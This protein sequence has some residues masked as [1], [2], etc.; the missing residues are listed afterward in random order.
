MPPTLIVM[1]G[2]PVAG[3]SSVAERLSAALS[4]PVLS[5]DLIAAALW[6]AGIPK[7][8]TGR[9]PYQVA[10][11]LAAEQLTLGLSV[12]VDAVNAGERT[13]ALWRSLAIEHG[14]DLRIIECVCSDRELHQQRVEQRRRDIPGMAE[15]TWAWVEQ[16]RSVYKP[17]ADERLV[18]ETSQRDIA[19]LAAAAIAYVTDRA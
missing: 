8:A 7:E 14:V 4:L 12:I 13:R 19:D 1:S 9:A 18:L 17:W 5:V 11:A 16:Q 3:K 15:A 2:L 6:G 10:R